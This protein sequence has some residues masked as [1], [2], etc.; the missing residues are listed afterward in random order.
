MPLFDELLTGSERDAV[1]HHIAACTVPLV[2]EEGEQA[3]VLGT[4]NLFELR[5]RVFLVTAAHSFEGF[6]PER[7]GVPARTEE[8]RAFLTLNGCRRYYW[9]DPEL[10]VSAVEVPAGSL[11]DSLRQTYAF[12]GAPSVAPFGQR[13]QQYIIVGY[14]RAVATTGPGHIEPHAVKVTSTLFE[15][16]PPENFQP[17]REFLLHFERAG[18]DPEGNLVESPRL[19]GVSGA[20]VWGVTAPAATNGLWS[21]SSSVQVVGVQHAV[22]HASYIRCHQW[23]LV[24]RMFEKIDAG[25]GADLLAMLSRTRT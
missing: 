19:H 21:A 9:P 25:I 22:N 17:S 6:D 10:D 2:E 4:A 20:A 24:A 3:A 12:L 11:L 23:W 13:F 1:D 8:G 15:G 18:E 14:P 5:E 7:V 16:I